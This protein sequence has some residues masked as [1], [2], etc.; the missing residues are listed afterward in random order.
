VA[1]ILAT[2][3]YLIGTIGMSSPPPATGLSEHD[4][5]VLAHVLGSGAVPAPRHGAPRR[6]RPLC[7]P[8]EA[9]A[10]RLE[11]E[12]LGVMLR[13]GESPES[14]Q[15]A[16]QLLQR[17][18]D[19]APDYPSPYN[20]R[21]QVRRLCGAAVPTSAVV[22]DLDAAVQLSGEEFPAVKQQALHHRAWLHYL[23][24]EMQAAFVD[25][26]AAGQL[27]SEEARTMATR[28]NPFAR[29][30]GAAVQEMLER[31]HYSTR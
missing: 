2:A 6:N 29:L 10:A 8:A 31:T 25:F 16:L 7:G 24:G 9:D 5:H 14:L 28:C 11:A 19:A 26:E 22:A 17:A 13:E 20:N 3:H 12:A 21:A 23:A 27:G 4:E 30:C 18:I 15:K 1:C